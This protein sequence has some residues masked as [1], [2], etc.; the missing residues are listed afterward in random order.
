MWEEK[1]ELNHLID[2][3]E[4]AQKLRVRNSWIYAKTRQKGSDAMP[5]LKVGKY[6][7][8]DYQE[9]LRWLLKIQAT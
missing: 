2:V 4:L 9:I 8:F 1:E 5:K 6:L 7:R 3:E